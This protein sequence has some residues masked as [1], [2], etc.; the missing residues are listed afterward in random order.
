MGPSTNAG[1]YVGVVVTNE[2]LYEVYCRSHKDSE[3][4]DEYTYYEEAAYNGW[5]EEVVKKLN[6]DEDEEDVWTVDIT[7]RT[8]D[9]DCESV[10]VCFCIWSFGSN[11]VYGNDYG[12]AMDLT[13]FSQ[14]SE[15][16]QKNSPAI[17]KLLNEL[18]I[19]EEECSRDLQLVIQ[20]V[21]N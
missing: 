21:S 14:M 4:D 1:V 5:V 8:D 2:I 15:I 12:Q 9:G 6:K 16:V 10:K 17:G 13:S 18:G 7:N 3:Y 19:S 11:A 20:V